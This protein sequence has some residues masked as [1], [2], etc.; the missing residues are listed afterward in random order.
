MN[1][2]FNFVVVFDFFIYSLREW[3]YKPQ[4]AY[5]SLWEPVY[6]LEI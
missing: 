5:N 1:T 2:M 4:G 6:K 3:F